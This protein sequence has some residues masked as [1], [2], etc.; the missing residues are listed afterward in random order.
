MS[1]FKQRLEAEKVL[2]EEKLIKLDEFLESGKA[3][4]IDDVQKA[5]LHVQANAMDT[6]L[7]CL[8]ERIKRL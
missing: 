7:Q 4:E 1:G 2:L 6:Y 3:E 5:L 8:K